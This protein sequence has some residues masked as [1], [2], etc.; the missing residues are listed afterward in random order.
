MTLGTPNFPQQP[1]TKRL[2]R[3]STPDLTDLDFKW[4]GLPFRTVIDLQQLKMKSE[5]KARR[6][7]FSAN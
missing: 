4:I 6:L 7:I 5:V 1:I 2:P 3:N